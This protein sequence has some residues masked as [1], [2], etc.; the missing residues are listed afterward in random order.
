[1]PPDDK[2]VGAEKYIHSREV[3]R[4]RARG[5]FFARDHARS[6]VDVINDYVVGAM[7][8]LSG[9]D[10]STIPHAEYICD[11]I[12]SFTRTHFI[13]VDLIVSSEL[14]DGTTLL[15]KQFELLARLQ[16]LGVAE[17]LD[18]LLERTPNLRVLKTDIKKLYGQ[19]SRIAHSADPEPLGLLGRIER[20]E[21]DYTPLY[22][23]FVD[24]SYVAL[25]HAFVSVVEYYLWAHPF[26]SRHC[27]SYDIAWGQAWL[28]RAVKVHNMMFDEI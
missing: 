23:I 2:L 10:M 7:F 22:P 3:F 17:S 16:E 18:D 21:G 26:F 6:L 27:R 25:N 9:Q 4:E 13:V 28:T 20:H 12:V 1:M 24:N 19:Y 8:A 11:L 15:R 14:I 5:Q